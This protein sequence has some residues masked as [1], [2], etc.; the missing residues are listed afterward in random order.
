MFGVFNQQEGV[1]RE[2]PKAL[3]IAKVKP[4][5]P[6]H[7]FENLPPGG[8]AVVGI[9]DRNNSGQLDRNLLGMPKEPVGLSNDTSLG[10]SNPPTF[11]KALFE[12]KESGS[13][14]VKL[15]PF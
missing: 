7:I 9:H 13:L 11:G 1:P 15:N 2:I 12:L 4:E 5:K 10:I 8:Y 14:K 3:V 6:T